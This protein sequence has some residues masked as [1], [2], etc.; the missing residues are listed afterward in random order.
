MS[1][2]AW[3]AEYLQQHPILLDEMLSA[4]LMQPID[5]KQVSQELSG[6]LNACGNDTEAKMD[7]LRRVQHAQI[8]RLAVQDLA[9]L[10]TVEALSDELSYL[11]DLILEQ[12]LT[13][14]WR[15]LPKNA[16]H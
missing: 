12:T 16:R 6:S 2:S 14:A 8:F 9:G 4:Q 5:W 15:S 10:W 1:Q 3:L 7:V 11:A 13:Y